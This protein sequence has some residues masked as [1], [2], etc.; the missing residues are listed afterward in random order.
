MAD[1][2]SRADHRRDGTVGRPDGRAESPEAVA[3]LQETVASLAV[4]PDPS[5]V[6]IESKPAASLRERVNAD[7]ASFGRGLLVVVLSTGAAL[8]TLILSLSFSC[9]GGTSAVVALWAPPQGMVLSLLLVQVALLVGSV[10]VLGVGC[11]VLSPTAQRASAGWDFFWRSP[12]SVCARLIGG[13]I[14]AV[15]ASRRDPL[16]NCAPLIASVMVCGQGGNRRSS[17]RSAYGHRC[18]RPPATADRG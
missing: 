13:V 9:G 2:W 3:P 15:I 10:R 5:K 8:V 4:S 16:G 11:L 6:T 17:P 14:P 18:L 12:T 7:L 1:P